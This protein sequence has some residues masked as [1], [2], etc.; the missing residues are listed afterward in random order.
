M[1]TIFA[2]AVTKISELPLDTQ[3]SIGEALLDSAAQPNLPVIEFTAEEYTKIDEAIAEIERGEV[4]GQDET[5]A[6]FQELRDHAY[7]RV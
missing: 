4:I 3:R 6:H 7:A 5:K 1:D 2:Q